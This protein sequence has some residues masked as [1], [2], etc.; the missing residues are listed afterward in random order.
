MLRMFSSA[1][2]FG[3]ELFLHI[4]S[5][6]ARFRLR[7]GS[8]WQPTTRYVQHSCSSLN[9]L[10]FALS[11]PSRN[12]TKLV[13][14]VRISELPSCGKLISP[15]HPKGGSGIYS[16]NPSRPESC[17]R[18]T[19]SHDASHYRDSVS[20]E[21]GI[22]CYVCVCLLSTRLVTIPSPTSRLPNS[23]P[24][25]FGPLTISTRRCNT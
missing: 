7:A 11:R 23:P 2:R 6:K 14:R 17:G 24:L 1:Q 21:P 4:Q 9:F 20:T 22:F 15:A 5:V 10:S 25:I 16:Y 18:G 19:T 12:T 3:V 8:D 13:A